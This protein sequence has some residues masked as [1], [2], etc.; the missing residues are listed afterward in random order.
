MDRHQHNDLTGANYFPPSTNYQ[1]WSPVSGSNQTSSQQLEPPAIGPPTAS[2][3]S[4]VGSTTSYGNTAPDGM[5]DTFGTHSQG[6]TVSATVAGY[7]FDTPHSTSH[8]TSHGHRSN[9]R[10]NESAGSSSVGREGRRTRAHLSGGRGQG[11]SEGRDASAG[12]KKEFVCKEKSCKGVAFSR[13]AD[14]ERHTKHV[15]LDADAKEQ[16]FCDYTDCSRSSMPFHRKDHYR[17]HLREFH[18]ED[19]LKRGSNAHR[20]PSPNSAASTTA[21]TPT[22]GSVS[23][24][25]S[26]SEEYK[27]LQKRLMQEKQ[28]QN[29]KTDPSWWRCARCLKR[30]QIA[31]CE[32]TC[33]DCR[34]SIEEPRKVIRDS[35][36]LQAN[37]SQASTSS[38]LDVASGLC[39]WTLE[40][41]YCYRYID[42]S[43]ET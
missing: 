14:L 23:A 38:S 20:A 29:S 30:V 15:H 36:S 8:G 4:T 24:S 32:W 6:S 28:L 25:A 3:T 41:Q 10:S 11:G 16:F 18:C 19:L 5:L 34:G 2:F 33:P 35:R 22:S 31:Q 21:S 9:S 17:E 42:N 1:N 7:I 40:T 26:A 39:P 27:K 13:V 43:S 37:L 12:C